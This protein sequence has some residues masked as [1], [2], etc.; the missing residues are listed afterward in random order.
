MQRLG[1]LRS[2]WASHGDLIDVQ[3]R[4]RGISGLLPTELSRSR[5][6]ADRYFQRVWDQWWRER[7]EFSDC[8]LPN[9]MWR[10]HGQRPANHPQRRLALAAHWLA[11]G[12]APP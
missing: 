1:E 10:F 12:P 7:D 4:L 11:A 8:L 6:G 5:G 9:T 2:R 3:A